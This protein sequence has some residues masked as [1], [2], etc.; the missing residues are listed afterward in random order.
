MHA[1]TTQFKKIIFFMIVGLV[2]LAWFGSE[3]RWQKYRNYEKEHNCEWQMINEM[4]IC[5]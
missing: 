2:A 4:E 1:K 5:K 3:Y